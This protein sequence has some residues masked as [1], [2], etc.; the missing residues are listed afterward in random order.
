MHLVWFR[1]DLRI[2]DQPALSAAIEAANQ[3]QQGVIALFIH[4]PQ[5]WQAHDRSAIQIDLERRSLALLA[6]SLAQ[7]NVRLYHL[8]VADFA[9]LPVA[10][11]DWC[12]QAGVRQ[13]WANAQYEWNERQRDVAVQQ[14]LD[15]Q[16]IAFQL[17][18]DQTIVPVG[19]I[20]TGTRTQPRYYTVFGAFERKWK[21]WLYDQPPAPLPMPPASIQTDLISGASQTLPDPDPVLAGRTAEQ[22]QWAQLWPA[23]EVAA[24][25][26]LAQFVSDGIARYDIER[27]LPA[28]S[29]I[30]QNGQSLL[31]ALPAQRMTSQLSAAL[32]LGLLSGRSCWHAAVNSDLMGPGVDKWVNELCWRDFYRQITYGFPRVSRGRAFRL[33]YDRV[34]WRQDQEG[35][36][37]WCQGRTGFP[38]VDAA[39]RS[40]NAQGWLHNRLRMVVASF[41]V[42][43]LLID[44]RWGERYFLQHLVDGDLSSNNGGW[45]W[46]A[47]SGC[48]PMPYFR[49]FNPVTQGRKIDPDGEFIRLWVP[50]LAQ[51]DRRYIHDPDRLQRLKNKVAADDPLHQYPAAML[52]HDRARE[53]TLLAYQQARQLTMPSIMDEPDLALTE[54]E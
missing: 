35:F 43:D 22:A 16:A 20:M 41:L 48:D 49:I 53:R 34:N 40:L 31:P 2:H 24:R 9:G 47:G 32:T 18:P 36:E 7:L 45:Q 5:Q 14:I 38:L 15:A 54:P 13:V 23:G 46:C 39:M 10:L 28:H 52:S 17:L 11:L 42:K 26:R 50:E 1:A 3:Q 6:E 51:V 27:N 8:E 37:R 19:E 44:W 12:Q 4:T 25:Q 29:R 33:I 30:V 21:Q